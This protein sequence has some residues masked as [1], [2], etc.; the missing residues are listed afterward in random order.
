MG[1]YVIAGEDDSIMTYEGGVYNDF[2]TVW[3]DGLD[4]RL[5]LDASCPFLLY[6]LGHGV[7][8]WGRRLIGLERRSINTTAITLQPC[9]FTSVNCTALEII[10]NF[11]YMKAFDRHYSLTQTTLLISHI[12][13][14]VYPSMHRLA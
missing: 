5:F 8:L 2:C 12:V 13:P 1:V 6:L 3:G 9:A 11:W 14:C 10:W 7:Y 4:A